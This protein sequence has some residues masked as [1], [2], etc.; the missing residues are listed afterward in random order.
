MTL[1]QLCT[2]CD[3]C[4]FM[5]P[6]L[7]CHRAKKPMIFYQPPTGPANVTARYNFLDKFIH[8]VGA[9]FRC[10]CGKTGKTKDSL[11]L[12]LQ[13][14]LSK[15]NTLK[16]PCVRC[17]ALMNRS[18]HCYDICNDHIQPENR[19]ILFHEKI[20][21]YGLVNVSLPIFQTVMLFF[22]S[23]DNVTAKSIKNV[24]RK[25]VITWSHGLL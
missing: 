10:I 18:R 8:R 2:Y 4:I 23:T 11:M 6:R 17:N 22:D 19:K 9:T 21:I 14:H 5:F 16:S 12:H 13:S 15:G 3:I 1:W 24:T 7:N 20:I 25:F